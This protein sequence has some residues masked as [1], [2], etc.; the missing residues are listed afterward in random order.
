MYSS[1]PDDTNNT[2]IE[3]GIIPPSYTFSGRI[4]TDAAAD[5]TLLDYI[6]TQYAKYARVVGGPA[7]NIYI[8]LRLSNSVA[9]GANTNVDFVD[10]ADLAY[11]LNNTYPGTLSYWQ[12]LDSPELNLT[13]TPEPGVGAS[14][15]M[16]AVGCVGLRRRDGGGRQK[17]FAKI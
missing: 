11:F 15:V 10:N 2:M 4:T 13:I 9:N 12:G 7:G 14:L 5:A 16:A 17:R 3:S 1:G 6:K 8:F